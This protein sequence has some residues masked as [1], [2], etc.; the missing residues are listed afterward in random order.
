MFITRGN[1]ETILTQKGTKQYLVI[2][3]LRAI[4]AYIY[5]FI[6]IVLVASSKQSTRADTWGDAD[7][8]L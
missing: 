5:S 1:N 2:A 7:E 4:D 3:F 6:I 8:A